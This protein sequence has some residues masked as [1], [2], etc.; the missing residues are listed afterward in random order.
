MGDV[1]DISRGERRRA[2][3]MMRSLIMFLPNFLK[4]MYK[5]LKDERVSGTDKAILVATIVYV[6]TPIDLI[7]DFVPFLGQ[8]DDIYAVAIAIIRII[9]R[10]SA[11]VVR[12][13]WDGIGD[14]KSI[15]ASI[16]SLS[17]FFLPTRVRNFLVGKIEPGEIASFEEYVKN[18]HSEE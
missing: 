12:Q 4:L 8:V 6:L 9:N 11:E 3:S 17:Q 5:L 18:R 15:V 14:I 16:S 7:P 13:H 2:R 1:V 10:T